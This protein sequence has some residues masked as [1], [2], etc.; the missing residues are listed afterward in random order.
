V[1]KDALNA[2]VIV[3]ITEFV[4]IVVMPTIVMRE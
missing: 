2:V 1:D 4:R 3:G